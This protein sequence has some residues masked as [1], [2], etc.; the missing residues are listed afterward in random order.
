M[1]GKIEVKNNAGAG[2]MVSFNILVSS[3]KQ[4]PVAFTNNAMQ[5]FEGKQVLIVDDN[6]RSLSILARQIEKFKLSPVTAASGKQAL[7]ILARS[8]IAAAVV[9]LMMP[10]MSGFEFILRVRQNITHA[11]LP[12]VVLTAKEIDDQDMTVLS[13][14]ANA[15]FLKGSPWRETFLTRIASLLKG[16]TK[17][18]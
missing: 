14:Q 10:E 17:A 12:I 16:V 5:A 7:E 9:D 1:S 2:C 4:Q 8:P 6:E 15:I 11:R 18:G 3:L 13:R